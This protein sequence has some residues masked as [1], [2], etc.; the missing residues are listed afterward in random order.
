MVEGGDVQCIIRNMTTVGYQ[1]FFVVTH[2]YTQWLI[3]LASLFCGKDVFASRGS[4]KSEVYTMTSDAP[5]AVN[6]SPPGFLQLL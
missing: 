1:M 5:S 2:G 6:S 3:Y 4:K